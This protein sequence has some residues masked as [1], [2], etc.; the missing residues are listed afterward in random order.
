MN[1]QW[2][3]HTVQESEMITNRRTAYEA[4]HAQYPDKPQHSISYNF[5]IR[6]K[7][8]ANPMCNVRSLDSEKLKEKIGRSEEKASETLLQF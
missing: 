1:K 7:K 4:Q 5:I 6:L 3:T 2:Y 8:Q